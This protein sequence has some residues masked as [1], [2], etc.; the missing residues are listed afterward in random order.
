MGNFANAGIAKGIIAGVVNNGSALYAGRKAREATTAQ[1]EGLDNARN[2]GEN[3][4]HQAVAG[5]QPYADYGKNALSRL[6][7]FESS[8]EAA[9]QML[10]ADPSYQFRL[11]QGM[12]GLENSAAARGGLLSGNTLKAI[13]DY[14]Q[15]AASQEYGNVWNRLARQAAMGGEGQQYLSNLAINQGQGGADNIAGQGNARAAGL[16]ARANIRMQAAQNTLNYLS[17]KG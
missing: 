14:N 5:Y 8:P 15:N 9:K 1:I 16:M 12:S 11:Q 13:S 7:Q 10:Y 4:Y 17:S 2:Y 3:Y 6:Q